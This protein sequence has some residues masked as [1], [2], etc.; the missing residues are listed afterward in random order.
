MMTIP[1]GATGRR[2][3]RL[4]WAVEKTGLC[5]VNGGQV[6]EYK[7]SRARKNI[8]TKP[9]G[10][11]LILAEIMS[12]AGAAYRPSQALRSS[13]AIYILDAPLCFDLGADKWPATGKQPLARELPTK[14]RPTEIS[15]HPPAALMPSAGTIS[16]LKN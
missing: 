6:V 1:D 7:K 9:Q 15:V 12:I 14:R 11:T 5:G 2:R 4:I 16:N 10:S 8:G 3:W 13:N